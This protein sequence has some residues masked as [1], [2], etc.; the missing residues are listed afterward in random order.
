GFHQLPSAM[1]SEEFQVEFLEEYTRIFK[2]LPYV[3]GEHVWNFADFQTKQGLQRFGGNKKGVF[4]R[5]RQPKMAAHFLRKSWE[6]K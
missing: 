6:T 2:K 4:T 1:F 5:E 3:I